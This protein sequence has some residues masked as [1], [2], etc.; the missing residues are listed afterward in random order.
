MEMGRWWVIMGL[1]GKAYYVWAAIAFV[2]YVLIDTIDLKSAGIPIISE[3]LEHH[4]GQVLTL[5]GIIFF[6]GILSEIFH[7]VFHGVVRS[8]IQPLIR[9]G[10]QSIAQS[11]TIG[12]SKISPDIIKRWIESGSA[13]GDSLKDIA[14]A[15]LQKHY[16]IPKPDGNCYI[17]FLVNNFLDPSKNDAHF[18]RKGLDAVI[19]LKSTVINCG[20]VPVTMLHWEEIKHYDIV[21]LRPSAVYPLFYENQFMIEPSGLAQALAKTD[22]KLK[23][24]PNVIFQFSKKNGAIDIPKLIEEGKVD[25]IDGLSIRYDGTWVTIAYK[26]DVPLTQESTRF[27]ATETSLM[28]FDDRTYQHMVHHPTYNLDI[29]FKLEGDIYDW[30]I[31][32][33]TIGVQSYHNDAD[34]HAV[35]ERPRQGEINLSIPNWVLPGIGIVVEWGKPRAVS[36]LRAAPEET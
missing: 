34:R 18:W 6:G 23:I 1:K 26:K 13:D 33:P 10:F 7:S 12:V 20:G 17:D 2:V 24:G 14:L 35:I 22:F 27:Y 31:C 19:T 29:K 25:E 3:I 28:S 8:E 30:S 4:K 36:A 16:A 9:N 32:D 21:S 5:A 11:I 15:S